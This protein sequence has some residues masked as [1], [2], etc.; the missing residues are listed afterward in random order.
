MATKKPKKKAARRAATKQRQPS[1]QERAVLAL[2]SI[3]RS[4]LPTTLSVAE[5]KHT[6]V[7]GGLGVSPAELLPKQDAQPSDAELLS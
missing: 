2:E 1:L 6:Q 4:L 7:H 3:A 5:Y